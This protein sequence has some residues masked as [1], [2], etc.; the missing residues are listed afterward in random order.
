M[1]RASPWQRSL[2]YIAEGMLG[3]P[4]FTNTPPAIAGPLYMLGPTAGFI[5]SWVLVAAIVGFATDR[6]WDRSALRLGAAM[7]A[8]VV[9]QFAMGFAWL[10]WF[11]QLA[12]RRRRH[13]HGTRLCR[14]RG[15]VPSRRCAEGRPGG[16][17]H[18][19][20]LVAGRPPHLTPLP[21]RALR[22]ILAAVAALGAEA[23]LAQQEGPDLPRLMA[24]D[25]PVRSGIVELHYSPAAQAEAIVYAD[26]LERAV[27]WYRDKTGWAGHL[28]MAVLNADD[29]AKVSGNIPYPS[30][31]AETATGLVVMP[32]RIDS[33]PGFDQWDLEPVGLNAAL[34]FHEIGHVIASQIGIWSD[35]YLGQRA[36]R[37]RLPGRLCA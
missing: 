23:A 36:G 30:P 20:K 8:A 3:L 21:V 17:A 7:L 1:A 10:A 16:A 35:N 26:A 22:W 37:Q 13:R 27:G 9:V 2:A 34:T 25:L 5:M 28:I 12:Q 14:R 32:D 19:G 4:V 29:W 24:L 15:A 18:P 11:A 31:Y 6:G 33:H